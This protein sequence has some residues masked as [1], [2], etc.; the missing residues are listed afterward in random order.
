MVKTGRYT[1]FFKKAFCK[2]EKISIDLD[3]SRNFCYTL[4]FFYNAKKTF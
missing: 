1:I 4:L 2:A 3:R